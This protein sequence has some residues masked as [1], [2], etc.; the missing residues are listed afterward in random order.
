MFETDGT[1]NQPMTG[2]EIAIIGMDGRFPGADDIEEFWRNLINGVESILFFNAEELVAAGVKPDLLENFDYVPA[3]AV[4]EDS[5]CFDATFFGYSPREAELMVPQMRIFHECVWRA[6]EDSGYDP[7]AYGGKIGFYAGASSSTA[8]EAGLYLSGNRQFGGIYTQVLVNKDQLCMRISYNLNLKGPSIQVQTACSTSL[9]AVHLAC[10]GLL[11]GECD[12][13]LAGGAHLFNKAKQGYLYQEGD[14]YSQ[15]SHCR[16]FDAEAKG[17]VAGEGAGVVVLKSLEDALSDGDNIQAVIKGSAIN[18]DGSRKV[19]YTAPSAQAQ[20]L[21]IRDAL[22]TADVAPE[23]IAYIEAHGTG[24]PVGDPIEIEALK[25]A[26]NTAKKK[27]CKIGSVKTNVGHL[28]ESAGIAGLIKTVLVLKHRLIPPSLHFK[29]PNPRIDFETSPF[30]VNTGLCPL[31]PGDHPLRAGVSSFGIGGTNVHVILEEAPIAKSAAPK[32]HGALSQSRGTASPPYQSPEYQLILLSAQ[33]ESALERMTGNL[34]N[35]LKKN[36]DLEPADVAYTL[37]VGR[38]VFQHRKMLVASSNGDVV[39]QLDTPGSTRVRQFTASTEDKPLVFMFPGQGAQYVNMGRQLYEKEPLFRQEMN[40]CFDILEPLMD[41]NIKEI[42][43]P[44]NWESKVSE[45]SSPDPNQFDRSNINRTEIAQPL[46][47][48]FE[49]ALAKLLMQWGIKP[50]ALTGHSIGEY[51]AA[52][53][54]GVLSLQNALTLVVCRGRLMQKMPV[55]AMLSVSLSEEQLKPLLNNRLDLAAVNNSNRC[56]VS[57]TQQEVR[58]FAR[59]L[60]EKGYESRFLHTSHAFHS[61]MMDPILAEFHQHLRQ[62]KFNP[63]N[64]PYISNR[65]GRWITVQE[66]VNPMYWVNHIRDTVRFGDGITE[67]VKKENAILIEVGPGRSLCTFVTQSSNAPSLYSALNLVRHPRENVNDVHYLLNKVGELWLYGKEINWHAFHHQGNRHRVSLPGYPFERLRYW[68]DGMFDKIEEKIGEKHRL[69]KKQNITHW[70]YA[71]SW[72][73]SRLTVPAAASNSGRFDS[74]TNYLV[75]MDDCHIGVQLVERM[76]QEGANVIMVRVGSEFK[77][78]DDRV[79]QVNPCLKDDYIALLKDLQ[80]Q[81]VIPDTVIHLWNVNR[82]SIRPLKL[83]REYFQKAQYFGFYSIL[84][85]VQAVA[86]LNFTGNIRLYVVANHLHDFTGTESIWPEKSTMLGLLKVIPQEYPH[87]S[88]KTIDIEIGDFDT[89][90]SSQGG[91]VQCPG[92][93]HRLLMEFTTTSPDT[94]ILYR[95]SHRWVQIFESLHPEPQISAP[96]LLKKEGVYLITG[97]LGRIG[98]ILAGYLSR[99]CRARLVLTGRSP[100]PPK[101]HWNQWLDTHNEEDHISQRILKL[102]EFEK[103]GARVMICQADA[104]DYQQVNKLLQQAEKEFGTLNGVIHCA[105]AVNEPMNIIKKIDHDEC[106]RQFQAKVYGLLILEKLLQDKHLDFCLLMSSISSVL[107]GLGYGAY[108]S[109]NCFM[110][111]FAS[112]NNRHS[113]WPCFSINWDA[114][115]LSEENVGQLFITPEEGVT[116]FQYLLSLQ[117]PGPMVISTG[118]LQTRLDQ[119][120]NLE[121][122]RTEKHRETKA[123]K[124]LSPRKDLMSSYMAPRNPLEQAL[125]EIWQELF[126]IAPI[127]VR[128]NFFEL[129]GDSLLGITLINRLKELLGEIVHITVIFDAPTAE[130]LSAYIVEQYPRAAARLTGSEAAPPGMELN[131]HKRI[132][133]GE[134][135]RMR[136]LI[137]KSPSSSGTF[138]LKEKNP[139]A[140]FILS[141]PRSGSTLLRVILAGHPQLF[142]PPE[143]DMLGFFTLAERNVSFSERRDFLSGGLVR[144][145]MQIKECSASDAERIIREYA[146]QDMTIQEF[147]RVLQQWLGNRILVDKT[148]GYAM[149]LGVLKQAETYFHQPLYIHLVRHPY[150]MIRSFEEAKLDLLIDSRLLKKLSLS[151]RQLAELYWT[152]SHQNILEFLGQV[153]GKRQ[154]QIKFEELVQHPR[155]TAEG[156]CRFLGLDF[157]TDMVEPYKDKKERMTDGVHE[158]G[159]MIGDVKFHQHNKIDRAVANAWEKHYQEEFLGN[160]AARMANFLGYQLSKKDRRSTIKPVSKKEYYP[161]SSPQNR[162]YYINRMDAQNTAYNL[163]QLIQLERKIEKEKLE[164]TVAKL[165]QRHES[166]RTSFIIAAGNPVQRIHKDVVL[167]ITDYHLKTIHDDVEVNLQQQEDNPGISKIED[168]VKGFVKPFDLSQAP[169]FRVGLIRLENGKQALLLDKHH[170]IFDGSSMKVLLKDFIA[171]YNGEKLP[172]L[173]IQYKDYAEWQNSPDAK[174]LTQSQE[175]Y[176]LKIFAGDVPVLHLPLDYPRPPVSRL[177]VSVKSFMVEEKKTGTLKLI[178]LEQGT[179]MFMLIMAIYSILLAKICN[180]EDIV[181]GIPIAGRNYKNLEPVIGM[182]V[183]SL[184]FRTFPAGHKTFKEFLLEVKHDTL[185]AFENQDYPAEDLVAQVVDNRDPARHPLVDVG[186]VVVNT[187]EQKEMESQ[188]DLFFSAKETETMDTKLDL[189]LYA[190]V[191]AKNILFT[192]EYT[193]K[194]FK[195]KTVEKYL[196]Y[197]DEIVACMIENVNTKLKDFKLHHDLW[198]EKLEIPAEDKADFGF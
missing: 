180:Q 38:S 48:I 43:Y 89:V 156:L 22:K 109:A 153:P 106:D 155:R 119:W 98:L 3:S 58:D 171:L 49:Y 63:P 33:T 123:P 113:G 191:M 143:L 78:L 26:F 68:V 122:L 134:I 13:A 167:D 83:D 19:G 177:A 80:I 51:T 192:F 151:R 18:N 92:L 136:Q 126:G 189:V 77:Q 121:T 159:L 188:D 185:A 103:S 50:Y 140:I 172:P 158:K 42:L 23:T 195:E 148:P 85:I 52:C 94:V 55:G 66:V 21:V 144:A 40:R 120:V 186:L 46:I 114:W 107:G 168:I 133:E 157:H 2:L 110:D 117:D 101:E 104:A 11:S 20:A 82:R 91:D 93:I 142:S 39:K 149:N 147:Y 64:L 32:V 88:C 41:D 45:E 116:V 100:F 37:Q 97:G 152:I 130:Q 31:E 146:E 170:I 34:V 197:L 24:T 135:A 74:N 169:L 57:G 61:W 65:T 4:L 8:W 67:L 112:G 6:L 162:L 154:Y 84:D 164:Q 125:V 27:F 194:L 141:P 73:R 1:T 193:K 124:Y 184:A 160:E 108:S 86:A 173:I 182:F 179:T 96:A 99:T 75:F 174:E 69:T 14:I 131:P 16:T 111:S 163:P 137:N 36:P 62:I 60:K 76:K 178:A 54:A 30:M 87:I 5:D 132:D 128:D 12:M 166:L 53:L 29:Q 102:Q 138:E 47:F 175:A 181:I 196:K 7:R 118:D 190:H 187:Q 25:M 81:N 127:G 17:T 105:G 176:W 198:V 59:Q 28:I 129:G 10:Q 145:I 150:A 95:G 35:H 139:P 72:K 183:N 115:Q 9:A 70:F 161:L 165:I 79:Y 71:P 90:P 15:D 44:D 56:V